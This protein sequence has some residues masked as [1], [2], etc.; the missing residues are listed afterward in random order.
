MIKI[1]I[2]TTIITFLFSFSILSQDQSI[3]DTSITSDKPVF[4]MEKS[5]W[6][7]V[8]RSTVLPG[9]GQFYNEDY[10]HIPIIWGFLG[11]FAYNWIQNNNEYQTFRDLFK[12]NPEN[13]LYKAQRDFYRDQRDNFTV[14][15]FITYLLNLVDAYVGAHLFDFSVEQN[16]HTKSPM[17]KFRYHF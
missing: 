17:L 11:W 10:W 3:T 1:I 2:K 12:E 8:G 9:W 7:A 4:E 6:G 5:P 15:I 13:S 16:L 14:Y